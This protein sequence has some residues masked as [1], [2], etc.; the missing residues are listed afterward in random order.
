MDALRRRKRE[1]EQILVDPLASSPDASGLAGIRARNDHAE[2]KEAIGALPVELR[3]PLVL[4]YFDGKSV[5][6]VAQSLGI[7]PATVCERL[8][9]ARRDLHE[10]MGNER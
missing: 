2:L 8:K 7:S 6:E 10:Q 1:S 3:L 5:R 9:Q 4:Y